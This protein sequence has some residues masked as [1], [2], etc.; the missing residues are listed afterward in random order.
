MQVCT[1]CHG[2]DLFTAERKTR[3]D[4]AALVDKMVDNGANG[5]D[6]QLEAIV[7]YLVAHFGKPVNVN[8]ATADDLQLDLKFSEKDALAVLKTRAE[9]GNFKSLDDLKAV[10]G[11]DQAKVN[12][13]KSSIAF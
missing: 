9:K 5:T 10:P 13:M 4:W 6:E 3:S 11:I 7:D 12:E 8:K 1:V 2:P